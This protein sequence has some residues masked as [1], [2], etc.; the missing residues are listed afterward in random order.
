MGATARFVL[1]VTAES[2]AR[3]LTGRDGTLPTRLP[4]PG[5]R[6]PSAYFVFL[7]QQPITGRPIHD[8]LGR[9][10]DRGLYGGVA[11]TV[12]RPP[13]I[14]ETLHASSVVTARRQVASPRG[15]LTITTLTTTYLGEDG[16]SRL[17]E[18]VR[19]IDLPAGPP[20][21]PPAADIL[22]PAAPLLASLPPITRRQVAWTTVETGDLN[23]LHLD[24]SYAVG[25]GFPDVVVPAPLITAMIERE[26]CAA[27]SGIASLDI[28]YQ[29]PTHPETA[30]ALHARIEDG[31]V[32][33][34]VLAAGV[35]RAQGRAR[36]LG[37]SST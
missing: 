27:G 14:G 23:S 36:K 25:R 26:I 13:R 16:G 7:R 34:Q 5:D 37:D 1:T 8:W 6:V 18:T 2:V 12:Q 11:Y 19:M 15:E 24:R 35:L 33:F 20:G 22:T 3:W 28:R 21:A 29:A 30:L 4:R 17:V 9:D 10:P 31:T 32:E